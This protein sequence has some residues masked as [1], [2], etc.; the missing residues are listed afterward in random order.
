MT[1]KKMFYLVILAAV[2]I[3]SLYY[4]WTRRELYRISAQLKG[5]LAFPFFGSAWMILGKTHEGE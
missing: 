3:S 2:L 5:P 4:I 1:H